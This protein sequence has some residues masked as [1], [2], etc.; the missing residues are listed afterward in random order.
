MLFIQEVIVSDDV[1]TENFI[2]NLEA[3]KGACCWEG[4]WGAPL[5]KEELDILKDIYS[6]IRPFL[7]EESQEVIEKK[8]LYEYFE[9]MG[10]YGTTLHENGACA[11]LTFE[12]NGIA[13]CGIEKA[14]EAGVIEFKK[15]I[16][17]HLYPI[18]V[19]KEEQV[20]FEAI[21]YDRWDICSAACTKGDKYQVKVYEFLKEALIRKYGQDWYEELDGAVQ[22]LSKK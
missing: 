4:E 10:D 5:E 11:Y 9:D 8:G 16:S 15:P 2:C 20:A 17:C 12:K 1:V 19:L 13:K 3:C 21:N 6:K 14:Y 18:R 22:H 7:S